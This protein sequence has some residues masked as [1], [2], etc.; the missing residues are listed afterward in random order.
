M[1]PSSDEA[2]RLREE[3]D[4]VC[5]SVQVN[6]SIQR[7]AKELTRDLST[8]YPL[9]VVVMRG[10]V[11]FAG[12]L[13]AYLDFPLELEYV[14][15]TRYGE[16]TAGRDIDWRITPPGSVEGRDVVLIDDILDA[17][18]TLAAIRDRIAAMG[19]A[20]CRCAV[21][22]EKILLEPKPLRAEYVGVEVPNRF[23]FGCGMDAKGHWRNLP[24][25]YAMK[26]T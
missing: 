22:A 10:G 24:A 15:A 11:Y 21:L 18:I 23:V 20:S 26:G 6:E 1:K 3:A 2:L 25:I 5:T 14:H 13:M 16:Q 4:L 8:H 19:A 7:V 9:F 17:G 12:Q